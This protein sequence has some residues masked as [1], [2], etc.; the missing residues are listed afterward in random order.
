MFT[1]QTINLRWCVIDENTIK[2]LKRGNRY[3]LYKFIIQLNYLNQ[4]QVKTVYQMLDQMA[5]LDISEISVENTNE[6]VTH[7]LAQ[8]AM[9]KDKQDLYKVL[10]FKDINI[11]K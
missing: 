6:D 8:K 5:E 9:F 11:T 3:K 2:L 4:Q 1:K 10:K 7:M